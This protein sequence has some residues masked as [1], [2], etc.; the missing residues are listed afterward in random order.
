MN[1]P[2]PLSYKSKSWSVY[3]EALKQGA[4]V[5]NWF[6]PEIDLGATADWQA[7]SASSIYAY[8][9]ENRHRLHRILGSHSTPQAA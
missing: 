4:S 2:I 9:T 7:G 8:S 1:S 5:A 6:D 3:H